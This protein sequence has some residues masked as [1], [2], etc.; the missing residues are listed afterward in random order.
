M[1]R[2]IATCEWNKSSQR[3]D[4]ERDNK[5]ELSLSLYSS[6]PPSEAGANDHED[7]HK[8]EDESEDIT[9]SHSST[10]SSL[11]GREDGG[12]ED[13]ECGPGENCCR[14]VCH[15]LFVVESSNGCVCSC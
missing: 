9:S 12:K 8:S 6:R 2:M 7:E 5:M 13:K 4:M 10:S 3:E 15:F 14:R 1:R 11:S